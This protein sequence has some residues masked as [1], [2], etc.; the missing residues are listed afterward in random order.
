MKNMGEEEGQKAAQ[1]KDTKAPGFEIVYGIICLFA[2]FLYK[3]K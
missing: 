2:I 3:R 1:E